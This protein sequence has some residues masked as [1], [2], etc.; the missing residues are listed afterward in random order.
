MLKR[1]ITAVLLLC[2]VA[3]QA[4]TRSK[5]VL[6]ALTAK[7]A[8]YKSYR[9]DFKVAAQGEFGAVPGYFVVS[10]AN[11]YVNVND[12]EVF[13]N[14]KLKYTYNDDDN[15]VLIEEVDPADNNIL[16][17]PSLFLRAYDK[18]FNHRHLGQAVQ[19]GRTLDLIELT[20]KQ[21]GAG[22]NALTL[23]ID[24]GTRQLVGISYRMEGMSTVAEITVERITPNIA[25]SPA[26]FAFD[27]KKYPGV[28]VIDF[29]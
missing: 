19:G 2:A 29:R 23:K 7:F 20:P 16:S 4:D 14:G 27:K 26:T 17:N 5:T 18:D 3:A 12:S 8:E 11:Y 13:S 9:V 1:V 22:Y 10:G 24:T 21:S 25:V 15:E 6:D 28:E